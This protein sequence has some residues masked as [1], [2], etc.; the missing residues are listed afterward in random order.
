MSPWGNSSLRFPHVVCRCPSN[1]RTQRN[2]PPGSR[3]TSRLNQIKLHATKRICVTVMFLSTSRVP[4][5]ANKNDRRPMYAPETHRDCAG[6]RSTFSVFYHPI[7]ED[8]GRWGLVQVSFPDILP[9]LDAFDTSRT[10]PLL[11]N[12]DGTRWTPTVTTLTRALCFLFS[13]CGSCT[14]YY[15]AW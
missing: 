8:T 15:H 13:S 4:V 6:G 5:P 1:R 2:S 14:W 11:D 12:M 9:T 3:C 7:L 10:D